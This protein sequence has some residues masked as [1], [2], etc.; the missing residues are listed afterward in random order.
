MHGHGHPCG[1][2]GGGPMWARF[3]HRHGGGDLGVR[4]PLRFL[5]YKLDLSED[6]IQR[7]AEILD[8]LKI[9]RAQAEVDDR[10]ALATFAEG[11]GPDALD[12]TKVR[13]AAAARAATAQRLNDA[14]ATALEQLHAVLEAD[15]RKQLA[16]LL[17]TGTLSI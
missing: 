17:R 10:R 3:G 16:L 6:Q 1:M 8:A 5:A 12:A 9:E 7:A 11:F 13:A 14:V 4:R 15:Q 2:H